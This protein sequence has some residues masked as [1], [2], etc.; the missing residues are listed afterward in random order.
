MIYGAEHLTRWSPESKVKGT[1]VLVHGLAEHAGRYE[2][3]A[4]LLAESGYSVVAP[5]LFGFG[6][7]GGERAYIREWSDYWGQIAALVTET[8]NSSEAPVV[9]LGHSLG[10]LIAASYGL[11]DNPQPDYLVLSAP[12]I[13]GGAW[14]Q[15]AL[16]PVLAA[17]APKLLVPN[18]LEGSQLSRDPDVGEAYFADPLVFT[19][20]SAHLG[21]EI[22]STQADVSSRIHEWHLPTLVMH[23]G[24]DTIVP[25]RTSAALA[26]LPPVERRLYTK[27]RHE[28]FNEPEGPALVSEVVEWL[29]HKLTARIES[30][31]EDQDLP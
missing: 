20:S 4:A 15:K 19:K 13:G 25:A 12:S 7:S 22:F 18:A 5:D 27:L 1:V 31:P 24:A 29:D 17:V 28:I 16:A 3:T 9:L 14:W 8:R 30:I 21:K 11:S 23:G 10:G 26:D 6:K 2:R